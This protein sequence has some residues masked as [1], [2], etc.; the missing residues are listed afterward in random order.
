[1][2]WMLSLVKDLAQNSQAH[3]T[4]ISRNFYL[5]RPSCCLLLVS[6][7]CKSPGYKNE[8][9]RQGR[10]SGICNLIL[11]MLEQEGDRV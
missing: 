10:G 11:E 4:N 2:L 9:F 1:M 3:I 5:Q 7:L 6:S 8:V